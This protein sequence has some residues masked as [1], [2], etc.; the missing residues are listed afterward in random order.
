[1]SRYWPRFSRDG[2]TNS[3]APIDYLEWYIPRLQETR[4]HNLSFS[5]MQYD[6]Q[7]DDLLGKGITELN[8]P[9]FNDDIDPRV[10]IAEREN[11]AVDNVLITHGATQGIN[12][13]LL[14]AIAMIRDSVDGEI[15]VAVESP[16]YAPIPQT[17][18]ILADKV[19]RMNKYPP[20]GNSGC[21]RIDRK[22]WREAIEQSQ[23]IM[24]TPISNPSGWNLDI[25]DRDWIIE[26]AKQNEVIII[27]D[28]AYNDAYRNT[29]HYRSLHSYGDKIISINSLTKVYSMGSIRFGWIISDRQTISIAR[30][31]FMTFSGVMAS[32][33]MKIG[34]AAL[35]NLSKVD[36]AITHYRRE[37]LPQLRAVLARHNIAWNEPPAGV[38]G[39]FELP[40]NV[41][42]EHF[43]DHHCKANDLLAVPCSMFSEELRN[44]VRVAWS[45][46]PK[47]FKLAIEALD[48]SLTSA[49]K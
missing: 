19:I 22:Q 39:C 16:T 26:L 11:V 6:W 3:V 29:E 48:K 24:V 40:N 36:M 34:T 18:L 43:V 35:Q 14:T 10:I 17:A 25:R 32:P 37:N 47:S 13:S 23:I 28:E 31:I 20:Q 4:T 46:E 41:D 5:G 42:S 27:A 30:R 12:I 38:F 44:W 2:L 9:Y 49:L 7:L 33:T 15:T 8:K 1:M 21:W 45:I